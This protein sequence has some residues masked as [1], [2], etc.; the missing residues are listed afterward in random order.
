M[1]RYNFSY[2]LLDNNLNYI[3]NIYPISANIDYDSLA[4]LK[5]SSNITV[6]DDEFNYNDMNIAI[7][8]NDKTIA[9]VLASTTTRKNKNINLL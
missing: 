2:E 9:T 1:R 5:V 7:K 8:E 3:R 6:K 4:T